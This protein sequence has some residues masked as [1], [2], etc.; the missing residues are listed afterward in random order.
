[1]ARTEAVPASSAATP[2]PGRLGR[3]AAG[4]MR[5]RGTAL[6]LWL[7]LVAA[8]TAGA[9]A[10]GDGYRND[11]SLPGT[12]SQAA[13]DLLA[14]HGAEAGGPHRPCPAEARG[15]TG[16]RPGPDRRASSTR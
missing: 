9:Q 4:S 12:D 3:I 7:V 10:A 8:L 13:A 11:H 2:P 5:H 1:M 14:A 15:R 16:R 6:L